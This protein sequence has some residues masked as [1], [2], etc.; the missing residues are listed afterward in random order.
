[1]VIRRYDPFFKIILK[2]LDS[3]FSFQQLITIID[4]ENV[5]APYYWPCVREIHLWPMGPLTK[6]LVMPKSAM[7]FPHKGASNA[8]SV[9]MSERLHGTRWRHNG[10]LEQILTYP[11]WRC[12]P[13][14]GGWGPG[15]GW[16]RRRRPG[17]RGPAHPG[18]CRTGRARI[19]GLGEKQRHWWLVIKNNGTGVYDDVWGLLIKTT[20]SRSLSNTEPEQRAWGETQTLDRLVKRVY[21]ARSSHN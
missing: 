17:H 21:V 14:W 5:N 15:R 3:L 18:P 1:M 9:S 6:G 7:D 11:V 2:S 20:S 19:T 10:I 8:E 12:I 16:W 13:G 4:K